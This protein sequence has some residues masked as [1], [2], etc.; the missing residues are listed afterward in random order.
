VAASDCPLP[1]T[2][3][4]DQRLI[5]GESRLCRIAIETRRREQMGTTL[6]DVMGKVD[7]MLPAKLRSK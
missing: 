7:F 2:V 5:I 1:D 6:Y 3:C 4:L